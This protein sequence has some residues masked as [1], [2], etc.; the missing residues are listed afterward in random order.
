MSQEL[1]LKIVQFSVLWKR[2]ETI[3]QNIH[4]IEDVNLSIKKLLE[5]TMGLSSLDVCG[6]VQF[7]SHL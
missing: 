2:K 7:N 3:L 5:V 6:Q 1:S 4:L